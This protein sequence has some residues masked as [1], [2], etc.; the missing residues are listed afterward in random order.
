MKLFFFLQ[1]FFDYIAFFFL[2][3]F[4]D[5]FASFFF[6]SAMFWSSHKFFFLDQFF[7]RFK[8]YFFSY[9]VI[10]LFFVVYFFQQFFDHLTYFCFSNLLIIL[11]CPNFFI[12]FY[13]KF[14]TINSY[15][16]YILEPCVLLFL[17][18]KAKRSFKKVYYH[19]Q[20]VDLSY[21]KT[22]SFVF[23][24]TDYKIVLAA[25]KLLISF[26]WTF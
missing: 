23:S 22:V 2:Q 10:I 1:S 20:M 13:N 9:F 19:S 12:I 8:F 21:W 3:Q 5:Q 17:R 7:D 24:I 18:K 25:W 4:W 16:S 6:A 11:H 26:M 15:T 14:I